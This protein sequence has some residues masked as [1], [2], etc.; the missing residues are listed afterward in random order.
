MLVLFTTQ[1]KY[2]VLESPPQVHIEQGILQGTYLT[3]SNG[4][5][6]AAF[7]GVP[8]ASPPIGKFRF[9]VHINMS[10]LV[11]LHICIYKYSKHSRLKINYFIMIKLVNVEVFITGMYYNMSLI[12]FHQGVN[13]CVYVYIP[14][15]FCQWSVHDSEWNFI[16]VPDS[17]WLSSSKFNMLPYS[18]NLVSSVLFNIVMS[19][20]N[21]L[22]FKFLKFSNM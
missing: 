5:K 12:F 3:S 18:S 1:L 10:S 16:T 20:Y 2:A 9:K 15:F 11:W 19:Q 22:H 4:R 21:V 7:Q 13:V 17:W 6:Y 8:Y 14:L